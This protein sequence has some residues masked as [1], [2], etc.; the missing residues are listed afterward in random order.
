MLSFLTFGQLKTIKNQKIL[1][2]HS[3]IIWSKSILKLDL[4]YHIFGQTLTGDK[5]LKIEKSI[6]SYL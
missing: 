6:A 2:G 3:P 1:V 4:V 5:I